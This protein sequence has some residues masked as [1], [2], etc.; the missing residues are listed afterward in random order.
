MERA[1][2]T[3]DLPKTMVQR[4]E[5]LANQ[6]QMS[7]THLVTQ[8]LEQLVAHDESYALA[9]QR[10][11]QSLAHAADLGTGG[12]LLNTRDELHARF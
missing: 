12:Q 10:H 1:S 6:R 11:L 7:V 2:I 8:T 4:I 3:L 5:R 9:R